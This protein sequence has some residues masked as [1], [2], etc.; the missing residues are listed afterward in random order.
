[1]AAQVA[2]TEATANYGS[3]LRK[4]S[5]FKCA[6]AE[7]NLADSGPPSLGR[8]ISAAS[9]TRNA[10]ITA[11]MKQKRVSV[12]DGRR[13]FLYASRVQQLRGLQR[14]HSSFIEGD[15][16]SEGDDDSDYVSSDDEVD[17][18]GAEE[19]EA[20]AAMARHRAESSGTGRPRCESGGRGAVLQRKSIVLDT[21]GTAHHR[22]RQDT[23]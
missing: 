12:T 5:L 15:E 9:A 17:A 16:D 10:A 22:H 6:K 11:A 13:D 21:A 1:M 19:A 7:A 20:A 14:Q 2:A 18:N 3:T 8:R 4:S 23:I